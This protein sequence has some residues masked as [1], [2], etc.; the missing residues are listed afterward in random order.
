MGARRIARTGLVVLGLVGQGVVGTALLSAPAF[1]DRG[2][3]QD[4]SFDAHRAET[5]SDLEALAKLATAQP[6][7]ARVWFYG[8]V[9]D[10]VTPGVPDKVRDEIRP[11]LEAVAKALAAEPVDDV[12]PLL[13]LDRAAS[14]AL[15]ADADFARKMQTEAVNAVRANTP[16][17][18]TLAAA[19]RPDLAEWV[20]YTLLYRAALSSKHLGGARESETMLV[21]ARRAAEGFALA[22]GDAR[23]FEALLSWY[24]PVGLP[25]E[26]AFLELA[27]DNALILQAKGDSAGARAGLERA[28][29]LSR[30]SRGADLMVAL[31][32]NGVAN[33]A[34]QA[35]DLAAEKQLRTQVLQ[36]VRPLNRP[37]LVALVSTQLVDTHLR[38]GTYLELVPLTARL[39]ALGPAVTEVR[40]RLTVLDRA[41][42]ALAKAADAALAKGEL[43][44]AE[45]LLTEASALGAILAGEDAVTR[46]TPAAEAPAARARRQA[47]RA[48]LSRRAGRIALRRGRFDEARTTF[49][50]A[51][52][53]Y[54]EG[55]SL[56]P[57]AAAARVDLAELALRTGDVQ[58]A[59]GLTAAA[60]TDLPT[61]APERADD[62]ARAYA[63]Q[64]TARLRA[65]EYAAAFANANAG[66]EALRA[67]D[68]QGAEPSLRARLHGLAGAALHA[69]GFHKEAR[70]R[71]VQA[72]G[73]DAADVD[74][75]L[76]AAAAHAAAGE[77]DAALG[78]ITATGPRARELDYV[79]GCLLV[80]AGRYNDALPVLQSAP[81]LGLPSLAHAR[82]LGSACLAEAQIAT[83]A[84]TAAQK[85]LGP[86]RAAFTA[87]DADPVMAWRLLEIDARAHAGAG[88]WPTAARRSLAAAQAYAQVQAERPARGLTLDVGTLMAPAD[89]GTLRAEGV[90]RCMKAADKGGP[91][92]AGFVETALRLARFFQAL[93]ASEPAARPLAG[94]PS[95]ERGVR[96]V[97]QEAPVRAALAHL[98]DL[99]RQLADP[100]L[101]LADRPALE[102][103][104]AKTADALRRAVRTLGDAAPA[105]R[106]WSAPGVPAAKALAAPAGEARIYTYFDAHGGHLW[107]S[108][109]EKP[110]RHETLPTASALS[111]ALAPAWAAIA[112][113][114]V[115]I[116]GAKRPK[117]PNA[118]AYATLAEPV[119]AHFGFLREPELAGLT[120][121][122]YADGPLARFPLGALVLTQP[123]T[124]GAPP[125]FV[126][127][128]FTV[129]HR[130]GLGVSAPRPAGGQGLHALGAA[131]AGPACPAGPPGIDLCGG[132]DLKVEQD[133]LAAAW[134]MAPGGFQAVPSEG[135]DEGR[136]Q[137]ALGQAATVLFN[138]PVDAATGDLL[139]PGASGK[140]TRLGGADLALGPAGKASQA[141]FTRLSETGRDGAD[142]LRHLMSA[143]NLRG[144][145]TALVLTSRAPGDPERI[146]A[147]AAR[148]AAGEALEA[149]LANQQRFDRDAVIDP[150]VGGVPSHHPHVWARM[151]VVE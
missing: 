25:E 14:G 137:V 35:G 29:D 130:L 94:R 129:R 82:T 98:G 42:I 62:R 77:F 31:V 68:R 28:L 116:P 96:P 56:P 139:L 69:E 81:G 103:T 125:E 72:V 65:G 74:L 138:G 60:L 3:Y 24:G 55:L 37:E 34:G 88:D 44:D 51:L 33:A 133:E 22:L 54:A 122:V 90:H 57:M 53:V 8:Q 50:A 112:T 80:R 124:V 64:G 123:A 101:E 135:L 115:A 59:L 26:R 127:S 2:P 78:F 46:T 20:F 39:R 49:E 43:A 12:L 100:A 148:L 73:F 147:L 18:A 63:V 110:L 117:D 92:A 9:F 114:P 4:W 48:E 95:G 27:V 85:S 30:Q 32:Q 21:T 10:L 150:K 118:A 93:E 17:G 120:L 86:I 47:E 83:G 131:I 52:T 128:K 84:Y 71:F 134:A 89:A 41:H 107:L 111:A 75:A 23:P 61:G 132:P 70:A 38:D 126:A 113:A 146:G 149:A 108:L 91:E 105:F 140:P 109:P 121:A 13:Y 97:E 16:I 79:R 106:A 144:I 142:G 145:S 151:I 76:T 19:A 11:R 136:V 102:A 7:F 99:R 58:G 66:L 15:A 40:Q 119:G 45:T 67:H 36:S 87:A 1:A 104:T 141:I 6:A 143:L 5:K